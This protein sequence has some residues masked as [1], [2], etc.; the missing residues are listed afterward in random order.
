MMVNVLVNFSVY[1]RRQVHI[2]R[3]RLLINCVYRFRKP[4]FVTV[5]VVYSKNEK[6]KITSLV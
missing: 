1:H 2:T 6:L 4:E 5:W 3:S